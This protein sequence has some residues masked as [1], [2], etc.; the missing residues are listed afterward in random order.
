MASTDL[1]FVIL[2]SCTVEEGPVGVQASIDWIFERR[3]LLG[4]RGLGGP[5]NLQTM[6]VLSDRAWATGRERHVIVAS[7]GAACIRGGQ[8]RLLGGSGRSRGWEGVGTLSG[9]CVITSRFVDIRDGAVTAMLVRR[10]AL[11]GLL[12]FFASLCGLALLL[13]ECHRG[14]GEYVVRFCGSGASRDVPATWLL[15]L[16]RGSGAV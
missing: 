9:C 6:G 12:A 4:G 16:L 14:W 8:G 11:R 7:F 2:R 10:R 3:G 15:R 13:R 1:L 5:S